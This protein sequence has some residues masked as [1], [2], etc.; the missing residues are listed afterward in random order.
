MTVSTDRLIERIRQLTKERASVVL[1]DIK[2][3]KG[4]L[5][6]AIKETQIRPVEELPKGEPS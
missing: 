4:E 2:I 1:N 6:G 3:V 5:Q